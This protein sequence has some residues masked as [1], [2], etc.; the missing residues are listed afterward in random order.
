MLLLDRA[1]KQFV[2]SGSL[3]IT[4]ADGTLHDYEGEAGPHAAIR[5]TDKRLHTALVFT[6]ELSTGEAYVDGTLILEEGT[7]RDFL[8]LYAINKA[9]FPKP[10]MRRALKPLV[11]KMRRLFKKN[12][13]AKSVKNVA[14][15]YDISNELY[16]LFL[17]DDLNYS[18]AYFRD[19]ADTLE[20]AQRNKLR[21]IAAKLDLKPGQRV[22]D[23][24]CGWGSMAMYLAEA[25]GVEVTGITLSVEQHALATKRAAE[26]GLGTR[27]KFE[28][29]DYR[30]MTGSFD[31]IV[32]V[33]M[34]EHVGVRH[35]EEYF[36]QIGRL[37][38]P[39]G[40][41]LVHTI[42]RRGGP[43]STGPWI[44]K[45]IFPGGYSPS[46]SEMTSAVEASKLW[47]T[48]VE[49]W[50]LHYA[51]TLKE[52]E[53][54]FQANRAAIAALLDERFCRMWEFYLVTSEYSFRHLKHVVFQVQI[55]KALETLPVTRDY[56]SEAEQALPLRLPGDATQSTDI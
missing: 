34:F 37:L 14:H 45:Y 35:Y 29:M 40:V 32:S 17:D 31:R 53:R 39:D 21:H 43:S 12:T 4:D 26:R 30:H 33:G 8:A 23:I 16:S 13:L 6:P 7:L 52:W 18:C 41:A 47:V 51:E 11:K 2:K 55:T 44:E 27:V 38:T 5:L 9:N 49:V 1:M 25:A 28:L 3:R 10:P 48:D 50:R 15:H 46:L 24:G 36:A 20:I 42:G 54:R 22:L 19:P 56:I